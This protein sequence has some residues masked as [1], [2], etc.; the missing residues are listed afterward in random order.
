MSRLELSIAES[1]GGSGDV[2]QRPDALR[3]LARLPLFLLAA[4][5]FG[6]L[7]YVY[8]TA[9]HL[10]G[11]ENPDNLTFVLAGQ[12]ML[13]GNWNLHGWT[14]VNTAWWPV[15]PVVYA[16]ALLTRGFYRAP[17]YVAAFTWAAT[18]A[19]AVW[20]AARPFRG[21]SAVAAAAVAFL[22]VGLPSAGTVTSPLEFIFA[23]PFQALTAAGSLCALVLLSSA[24][25]PR[26]A[27]EARRPV[28]AAL[29][30]AAALT[31]AACVITSDTLALATIVVPALALFAFSLL[32]DG[33]DNR[34]G[35]GAVFAVLALGLSRLL[36]WLLSATHGLSLIRPVNWIA[37]A[38][39]DTLVTR[40]LGLALQGV[41]S[42]FG[43]YWFDR[44]VLNWSTL[45]VLVHLAALLFILWAV[46]RALS[47]AW[48]GRAQDW[49]VA[50]LALGFVSNLGVYTASVLPM[51]IGSSRYLL[52]LLP[53]GGVVAA[54][55]AGDALNGAGLRKKAALGGAILLLAYSS[56]SSFGWWFDQRPTF[57]P[58]ADLIAWLEMQNLRYGY[59]PYQDAVPVTVASEGR[60]AVRPVRD[61]D[62]LL[63][64][65]QY[66]AKQWYWDPARFVILRDDLPAVSLAD[67]RRTFGPVYS[68][69]RIGPYQVV[70]WPGDK[71]LLE[72]GRE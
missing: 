20:I 70:V 41:I 48:A 14:L 11:L 55:A 27:H 17:F 71:P 23:A 9:A 39:F 10:V 18:V 19:C 66:S 54:R 30:A 22:L 13:K 51:D 1:T 38:P 58:R 64:P 25:R 46:W 34:A 59:A 6:A 53:F 35:A 36:F 67:V 52:A 29:L 57:P 33:R 24:L 45:I 40:N 21:V 26:P 42:F 16:G 63:R 50:V 3:V 15:Q 47:A 49:L 28:R 56:L 31:L 12:D 4:A 69:H 32:R 7:F 65:T 5:A 62:G 37:F 68:L 44:P 61:V 2:A 8:Y 60:L 43:A 72:P